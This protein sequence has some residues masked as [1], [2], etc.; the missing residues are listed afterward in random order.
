MKEI[1]L[2]DIEDKRKQ[3]RRDRKPCEGRT[4]RSERKDSRREAK[5]RKRREKRMAERQAR[6]AAGKDIR[7]GKGRSRWLGGLLVT[8]GVLVAA[9]S[10]VYVGGMIYFQDKFLPN[11]V[12]NGTD[13]SYCTVEEVDK[14]IARD[15]ENYSIEI[16]VR[17]GGKEYID[18]DDIDYRYVSRNEVEL[19]KVNQGAFEWPLSFFKSYEYSFESST[20]YDEEKL[21]DA[22]A[23]L[24]CMQD[25]EPPEDA[26]VE[27]SGGTY[28]LVKEEE[29]TQIDGEKLEALMKNVIQ[30]GA[31]GVSL[32]EQGCYVEPAVRST[33]ETL[34]KLYKNL[35]TYTDA[36]VEYTFGDEVE[37]LNGTTVKD[38]L[39]YDEEGNVT[40]DQ[41]KVT[42]YVAELAAEHDTYNKSRHFKTS[43]G[44]YVD[45]SGGSYGWQIDQAAEAAQLSQE[46]AAGERVSREP[47]YAQ[48]AASYDNCD[49]GGSYVE[50]DLTKQ[51]LWMYVD[52]QLVVESD[53]VSGDMTK[54][55]R[56]TPGGTYSL[57]YKVSPYVLTST[58]PGDSYEEPVT[59]WMPFNGGIGFHDAP[60][61]G[62]FG[63][64][65]YI[66]GG[67]HGCIN[68]P[69]QA[70]A[71][72]YQ[73]IYA[74]FPVICFYR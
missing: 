40:L 50:V 28:Q 43:D 74:G 51:H 32:E 60:W 42:Q 41:T 66:T 56:M 70:A 2:R 3:T 58:T 6:R 19:F 20:A 22:L 24:D 67:S 16:A 23:S 11:T 73:N 4:S 31:R 18:A 29:G 65:L 33:D 13:V 45:V 17:G 44:T 72:M 5:A 10:I 34:Q 61:R 26:R 9:V 71:T 47:L 1:T 68:L 55:G 59:Y 21:K 54:E 39:S 48:R 49:L 30:A 27:F 25:M 62:S 57:Y 36:R 38:W 12:I 35:K 8:A 37:V 69:M 52:Y 63:G 15:V 7:P 46:L 64:N 14:R 53:F